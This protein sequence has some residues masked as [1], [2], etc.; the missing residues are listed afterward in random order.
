MMLGPN[1]QVQKL[2]L[3][4]PS[5]LVGELDTED[6]LLT[7]AFADARSYKTFGM[8]GIP[9]SRHAFVFSFRTGPHDPD[10]VVL[11]D[12]VP[13]GDLICSYLS[14]LYG[15][16][17]DSHGVLEANGLF[18]L[19]D[20]SAFQRFYDPG[21]P[22]NSDKPRKDFMVP[23]KLEEA[24]RLRGLLM[25]SVE[26]RFQAIFDVASKFYLQA[27]QNYE[28]APE[29][30]YLH[31]ITAGEAL[32][33]CFDYPKEDLLD[34]QVKDA[35]AQIKAECA[36]GQSIARLIRGR[37][38]QVKKRFVKTI[39]ELLDHE[40]FF[41]NGEAQKGWR[42]ERTNFESAIRAAY[43]I[44]SKYVHEGAPFGTWISLPRRWEVGLKPD[45]PDRKLAKTL[46]K[47]P[48]FLGLERVIRHCLLQYAA[49]NGAFVD[50]PTQ[51]D[52]R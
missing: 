2:L 11:P 38:F 20:L 16:R 12:Y 1:E 31:L 37:L 32:S 50:D 23:L 35:L 26:E 29:V 24:G 47:A 8:M 42:L 9:T 13:I 33:E 7:H 5:H 44:R 28:R 27:V 6:F 10:G 14:V 36:N 17:F 49:K 3:S 21:L 15:K 34:E 22:F 51:F 41:D 52:G 39:V 43:D 46:S 18:W 25:K 45:L 40:T 4:S 30:A 19:P 48:T